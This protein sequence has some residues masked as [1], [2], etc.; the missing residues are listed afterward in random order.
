MALSW[1]R[2]KVLNL[3]NEKYNLCP[4]EITCYEEADAFWTDYLAPIGTIAPAFFDHVDAEIGLAIINNWQDREE[5]GRTVFPLL[6]KS[7]I[8]KE[9]EVVNNG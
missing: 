6:K 7:T 5:M 9:L 8:V 1:N 2:Y 3:I 4:F